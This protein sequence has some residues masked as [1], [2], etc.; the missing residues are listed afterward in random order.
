MPTVYVIDAY[1]LMHAMGIL[2]GKVKPL[3]LVRARLQFQEFLVKAFGDEVGQVT[4]VFDASQ[5]SPKVPRR[6]RYKG[7]TLLLSESQQEADDLI[8]A[9]IVHHSSPKHLVVVSSDRRLQKAA[10]RGGAQAMG[11]MEFLD[12]VERRRRQTPQPAEEE[13]DK[14][15]RLSE[16]EIR[17]WLQ[18]FAGLESEPDLKEALERFNFE[19]D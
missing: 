6:Q 18:E 10:R 16:S 14:R 5:A 3:G 4:A 8:E 13:A 1:N 12:F 15:D 11:C 19:N 7:L 9:I 17:T 2:L